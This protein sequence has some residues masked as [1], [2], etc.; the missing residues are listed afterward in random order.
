M[1]ASH[2]HI[3][4]Y[5]YIDI[6]YTHTYCPALAGAGT[7]GARTR[8]RAAFW[9]LFRARYRLMRLVARRFAGFAKHPPGGYAHVHRAHLLG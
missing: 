8:A 5:I 3:Y 2:T 7:A 1:E 6:I 9:R 4:I